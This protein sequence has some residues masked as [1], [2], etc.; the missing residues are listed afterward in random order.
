VRNTKE[1]EINLK[2]S[3][4]ISE[5]TKFFNLSAFVN[6]IIKLPL[7][8]QCH[9]HQRSHHGAWV[10]VVPEVQQLLKI[11]GVQVHRLANDRKSNVWQ[12]S[13]SCM[14]KS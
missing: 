10:H 12:K 6:M 9:T 5:S 2:C 11:S 4:H 8:C 1:K 7:I 14:E 3:H 13:E